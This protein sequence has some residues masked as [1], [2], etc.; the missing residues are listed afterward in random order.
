MGLKSAIMLFCNVEKGKFLNFL[1]CKAKSE[2]QSIKSTTKKPAS[3]PY[4][5]WQDFKF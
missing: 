5:G 2:E 4:F 3:E 1:Q